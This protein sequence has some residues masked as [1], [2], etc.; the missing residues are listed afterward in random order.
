[1]RST[2]KTR[3]VDTDRRTFTRTRAPEPCRL[4][5]TVH[6][7]R[8]PRSIPSTLRISSPC[9]IWPELHAGPNVVTY[10]TVFPRMPKPIVYCAKSPLV[11]IFTTDVILSS[12]T[13][14]RNAGGVTGG[15]R[16]S[17]P[18]P[19]SA[20]GEARGEWC[21]FVWKHIACPLLRCRGSWLVGPTCNRRQPG[22]RCAIFL[23]PLPILAAM[24][25]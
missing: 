22:S 21:G 13:G 19:A 11:G 1:M 9:S 20:S 10:S 25:E 12:T 6:E 7:G 3:S 5:T 8:V 14:C 2:S 18:A 4:F 15:D 24:P 23:L 17:L 16:G